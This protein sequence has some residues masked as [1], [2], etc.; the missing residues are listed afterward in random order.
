MMLNW[1]WWTYSILASI[2]WGLHFNLLVKVSNVLPRDIY[3]PLTLFFVTANSIWFI[4]LLAHKQVFD[5]IMTLWHAG[6]EIRWSLLILIA[7]TVAAATLLTIA[8]QLSNNATL[9]SLLDIT[10]PIFVA[11]VAWL[12]FKE[13]HFDWTMLVGGALIFSGS[14]LIIWKHG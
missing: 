8:M 10:Y 12:L 2:L 11:L 5:N 13:G 4:L 1:P 6:T 9:A 14:L 3:T 7:T